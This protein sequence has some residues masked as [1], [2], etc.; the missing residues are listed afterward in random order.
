MVIFGNA[1]IKAKRGFTM[2]E[3]VVVI[4]VL[5]ILSTLAWVN[6]GNNNG[7]AKWSNQIKTN[8]ASAATTIASTFKKDSFAFTTTTHTFTF[9]SQPSNL[10]ATTA[11]DLTAQNITAGLVDATTGPLRSLVLPT[12]TA[13]AASNIYIC[14]SN[15]TAAVTK[16]FSQGYGAGIESED[17][18][19]FVN[20]V[21]AFNTANVCVASTDTQNLKSG[22]TGGQD[23]VGISGIL[24]RYANS[25]LLAKSDMMKS[26]ALD[27]GLGS[28]VAGNPGNGGV[29][30][31]V[32]QL[33]SATSDPNFVANA[34]VQ[35]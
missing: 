1:A 4:T 9:N 34:K 24:V 20:N 28:S 5:A 15:A 3:L 12:G 22:T 27:G 14:P 26:D 18:I 16:A 32:T 11:G 13:I 10:V 31:Y 17:V 30:G 6:S 29:V 2:I 25:D 8:I 7:D 21:A 35:Y 33:A 19:V 23:Y